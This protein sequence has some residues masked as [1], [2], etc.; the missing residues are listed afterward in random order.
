MFT[1]VYIYT[2]TYVTKL[3]NM[4]VCTCIVI[5]KKM[6]ERASQFY[7]G[8]LLFCL[9]WE[10][11]HGMIY[12]TKKIINKGIFWGYFMGIVT[13]NIFGVVGEVNHCPVGDGAW[14]WNVPM[15]DYFPQNNSIYRLVRE[16]MIPTSLVGWLKHQ[17]MDGLKPMIRT[18]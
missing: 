9:V 17:N 3:F 13:N 7:L 1:Y 18:L 2:Y 5:S 6:P 8:R 12:P 4:Y 16:V 10:N 15:V 14:Q 11:H